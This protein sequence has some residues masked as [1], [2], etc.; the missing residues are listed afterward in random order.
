MVCTCMVPGCSA[1]TR[2]IHGVSFHRLPKELD[3]CKK[4]LRAI[5]NPKFAEDTAIE[6]LKNLTVCSLHFKPEDFEPNP[7]GVKRPALVKTAIPSILPDDVD[8]QPGTSGTA[9]SA[10]RICL[11]STSQALLTLP[12]NHVATQTDPPRCSTRTTQVSMGTLGPHMR[13]KGVQ[14]DCVRDTKM[15]E[16]RRVGT[17]DAPWGSQSS[18]PIRPVHHRPS[19]RPRLEEEATAAASTSAAN[20]TDT[21]SIPDPLDSTYDPAQSRTTLTES[22][23]L[24]DNSSSPTGHTDKKYIVFEKNLM[25]LFQH[26]PDCTRSTEVKTYRRGTFLSIDQKC[27]HCKFF[28]QWKCSRTK[29]TKVRSD[30]HY[31]NSFDPLST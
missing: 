4:W 5:N 7:L 31:S 13:S 8:E 30:S 6:A 26:C 27:H 9:S 29:R 18:T 25:E 11:E 22:S 14:F 23:Q 16:S 15:Y 21:L 12:L 20:V 17:S 24:S 19:K 1:S 2:K 3:L 28:R 10:K